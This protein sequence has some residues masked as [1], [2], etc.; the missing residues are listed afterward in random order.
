MNDRKSFGYIYLITNKINGK[1]YIGQRRSHI[2]K[3]WNQYYGSGKTIKHAISKYG[4]ENFT[5]ELLKKCYSLKE[6]NEQERIFIR[7][8]RELGKAEYNLTEGN[9]TV[10]NPWVNLTAEE[11]QAI[12]DKESLRRKKE[13]DERFEKL[14]SDHRDEVVELY[15]KLRH[16][17]KVSCILNISY[18]NI[19]KILDKSNISRKRILSNEQKQKIS[20]SLKRTNSLKNNNLK[21]KLVLTYSFC[22]QCKR[23][24]TD[25]KKRKFCDQKCQ[26]LFSKVSLDKSVLEDLY[27]NRKLSANEIGRMFGVTGQTVRNRMREL[28]I[29]RLPERHKNKS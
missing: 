5:K 14:Y 21:E 1:T 29:K 2:D 23:K 4:K 20:K 6:L 19:K 10:D 9:P 24:I 15:L 12:R 25:K 18:K 22:L 7:K 13:A 27:W 17:K 11:K 8:Y 26:G 3:S 16:M 28:K